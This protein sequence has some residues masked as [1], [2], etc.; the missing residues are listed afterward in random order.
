MI[1]M[2]GV[3]VNKC[4][5]ITIPNSGLTLNIVTDFRR[6]RVLFLCLKGN[7]ITDFAK[8]IGEQVSKTIDKKTGWM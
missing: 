1:F 4:I 8:F 7:D 6:Y 5:Y 3:I 2:I